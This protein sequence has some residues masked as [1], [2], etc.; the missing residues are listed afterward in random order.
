PAAVL[1]VLL[2][3]PQ[4]PQRLLAFHAGSPGAAAG[5][6]PEQAARLARPGQA[7]VERLGA[8]LPG[9]PAADQPRGV[10]GVPRAR[11]PLRARA[12]ALGQAPALPPGPLAVRPP[13]LRPLPGS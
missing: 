3:H 6:L 12:A 10:R 2:P 11:P 5:G 7:A 8:G 4:L 13:A 1:P 9:G